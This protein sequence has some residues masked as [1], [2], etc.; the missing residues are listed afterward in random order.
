MKEWTLYEEKSHHSLKASA[1]SSP[2]LERTIANE[3]NVFET[4]MQMKNDQ[5]VN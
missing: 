5:N 3:G 4:E 2:D 1:A